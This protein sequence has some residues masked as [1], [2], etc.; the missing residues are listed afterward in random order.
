MYIL[1]RGKQKIIITSGRNKCYLPSLAV[2]VS[3]SNVQHSSVTFEWPL[4]VLSRGLKKHEQKELNIW[5]L[6]GKGTDRDGCCWCPSSTH[7]TL[8]QETVANFGKWQHVKQVPAWYQECLCLARAHR[9]EVSVR[10]RE[11]RNHTL[12]KLTDASKCPQ[13]TR[14]GVLQGNGWEYKFETGQSNKVGF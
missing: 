2:Q 14:W 6:P 5:P 7:V 11:G 8:T 12:P 13:D 4:N 3:M 10:G 1:I 9:G